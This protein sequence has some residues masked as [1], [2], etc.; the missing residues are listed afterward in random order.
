M[1]EIIGKLAHRRD[2]DDDFIMS[3]SGARDVI[4]DGSNAFGVPHRRATK[5]LHDERHAH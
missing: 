4:G 5:L 1:D 2:H 3:G